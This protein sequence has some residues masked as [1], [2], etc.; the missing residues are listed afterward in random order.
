V[1]AVFDKLYL[2]EPTVEDTSRLLW[3]NEA[4]GIPGVISS[5]DFMHWEWKNCPFASQSQYNHEGCIIIL[6]AVASHDL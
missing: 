6:E 2:R 5:I 1:I 3:I 4:R